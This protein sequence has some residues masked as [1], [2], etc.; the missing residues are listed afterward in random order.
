MVKPED[1]GQGQRA[2]VVGGDTVAGGSGP[3]KEARRARVEI[4]A[5]GKN[6]T[7]SLTGQEAGRTELFALQTS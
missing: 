3:V 4:F 2:D 1:I 7:R 5:A 6:T